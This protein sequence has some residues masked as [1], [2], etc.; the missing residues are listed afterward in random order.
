MSEDGRDC[1]A[2]RVDGDAASV[3]LTGEIDSS[4]SGSLDDVVEQGRLAGRSVTVDLQGVTFMDSTGI[5]FLVRLRSLAGG[6]VRLLNPDP[7]TRRL[8]DVVAVSELF[9][10]VTETPS[11]G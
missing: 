4:A 6:R 8:L 2:V 11:H 3:T 10:V 5:G 9:D 1:V 7:F